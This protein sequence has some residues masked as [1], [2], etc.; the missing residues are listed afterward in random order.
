MPSFHHWLALTGVCA[1]FTM[2]GCGADAGNTEA[3]P[4][5]SSTTTTDSTSS[6]TDSTIDDSTTDSGSA[7]DSSSET[8]TT[9]APD[10]GADAGALC[11]AGQ[12]RD[13]AGMTCKS[14]PAATLVCPSS[15]DPTNTKF[16]ATTGKLTV[17]LAPGKTQLLSGK[18]KVAYTNMDDCYGSSGPST[19]AT[20][21]SGEI[22]IVPS[23]D[24]FTADFKTLDANAKPCGVQ[25]LTVT[26]ACC[27]ERTVKVIV[28]RDIEGG[29]TYVACPTMSD[30]G[31]DASGD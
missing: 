23:G 17:A 11:P 14:C 28:S 31:T 7:M 18:I 13:F 3:T 27:T 24:T 10:G 12:W 8:A 30:G 26:D 9:C 4:E 6:G 25:T 16:D 5:D 22:P 29:T 19:S 21:L 20:I 1:S 2:V 15:F